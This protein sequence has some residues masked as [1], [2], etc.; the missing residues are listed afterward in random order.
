MEQLARVT[1]N[2]RERCLKLLIVKQSSRVLERMGGKSDGGTKL[3]QN[4]GIL[5]CMIGCWL[6]ENAELKLR[7]EGNW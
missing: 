2:S 7:L 6:W 1:V 4:I 3:N 5:V